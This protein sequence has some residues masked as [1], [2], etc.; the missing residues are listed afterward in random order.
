MCAKNFRVARCFGQG[1]IMKAEQRS[2]S[3]EIRRGVVRLFTMVHVVQMPTPQAGAS[4]C[5][6]LHRYQLAEINAMQPHIRGHVVVDH[7][8]PHTAYNISHDF[9]VQDASHE[10]PDDRRKHVPG[11]PTPR[12]RLLAREDPQRTKH[13]PF[14]GFL[15]FCHLLG[16]NI[17]PLLI[18]GLHL[19]QSSRNALIQGD[20]PWQANHTNSKLFSCIRTG[21]I[22]L[23]TEFQREQTD[24]FDFSL[25]EDHHSLSSSP[26]WDHGR[27]LE[28]RSVPNEPRDCGYKLSEVLLWKRGNLCPVPYPSKYVCTGILYPFFRHR[29]LR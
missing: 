11:P 16:R 15:R 12:H 27:Y 14:M 28:D 19:L 29:S 7:H 17:H 23:R 13:A 18:V 1:K 25:H 4:V 24:A 3:R 5:P 26:R 8:I 20:L 2:H 10:A 9:L 6:F 21:Q 22:A